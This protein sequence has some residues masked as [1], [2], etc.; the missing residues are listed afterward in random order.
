MSE[1]IGPIS[2]ETLR[3]ARRGGVRVLTFD[4]G[5]S[6]RYES[7][8]VRDSAAY[9]GEWDRILI[10]RDDGRIAQL[11]VDLING[12]DSLDAAWQEAEAALPEGNW[13]LHLQR[14]ALRPIG[15]DY[16]AMADGWGPMPVGLIRDAESIVGPYSPTPA[17]ALR[18]LAAKLRERTG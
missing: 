18:A 9:A 11:L 6:E 13:S 14:E 1:A 15:A 10:A 4:N 7:I 16:L 17:A 8:F 12:T 3:V 5:R 2:A